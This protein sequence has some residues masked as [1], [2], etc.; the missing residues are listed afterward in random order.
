MVPVGYFVMYNITLYKIK[1]LT[2]LILLNNL[3]VSAVLI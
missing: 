3:I 2:A 1:I